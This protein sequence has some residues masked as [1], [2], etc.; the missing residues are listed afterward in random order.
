MEGLH[1]PDMEETTGS[2]SPFTEG[3]GPW[4]P[5]LMVLKVKWISVMRQLTM[6][7]HSE[8][9]I[10]IRRFCYCENYI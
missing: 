3:K 7:M 6:G 5:V 9:Y 8:K 2:R 4:A 10:V 1:V